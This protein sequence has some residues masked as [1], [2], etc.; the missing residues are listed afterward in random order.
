MPSQLDL[1][2]QPIP[3][4]V[5]SLTFNQAVRIFASIY[6]SKKKMFKNSQSILRYIATFFDG[7]FLDAIGRMD[8]ENFRIWLARPGGAT[9]RGLGLA[10]TNK[11][12]M[13][14][15]LMFNRLEDWK[16]DRWA[17]GYDFSGLALPRRNPGSL[18]HRP[19]DPAADRY[20]T[21][22]EFRKIRRAAIRLGDY[23]LADMIRFGIWARLSPIDLLELNDDEIVVTDQV[24]QVEVYRRHTKTA[25]N[26]QGCLQIVPLTERMWGLLQRWRSTRKAGET[27]IFPIKNMRRRLRKIRKLAIEWGVPDFTLGAMRRS[28]S[29]Y[30]YEK[31]VDLATRS[32]GMGHKTLEITRRHYTP[33]TR[34]HLKKPTT[35]LVEA[36]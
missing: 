18:V 28:G 16:E 7:Q 32:E 2:D 15:T 11:A 23:I 31:G 12:H 17:G 5:T 14:L 24:C 19:K 10:A 26:P 36:F 27:R 9:T 25:R 8:V 13:V 20:L 3:K 22:F 34:P 6:L 33:R 21:P 29:G 4:V 1:F 30:L 35:M